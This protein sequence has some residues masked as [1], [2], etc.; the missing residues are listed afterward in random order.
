[1]VQ[2]RPLPSETGNPLDFGLGGVSRHGDRVGTNSG[3]RTPTL[4]ETKSPNAQGAA[5]FAAAP[6]ST[7][8]LYLGAA[9]P[10]AFDHAAAIRMFRLRTARSILEQLRP[11]G[12][13]SL[14]RACEPSRLI[15]RLARS[16]RQFV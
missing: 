8:T 11:P 10:S 16:L 15:S 5:A 2:A 12:P 6:S 3:E 1:M 4:Q 13:S 7:L 14:R 9:G